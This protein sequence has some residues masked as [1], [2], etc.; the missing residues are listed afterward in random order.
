MNIQWILRHVLLVPF[1]PCRSLLRKWPKS[2]LFADRKM[3]THSPLPPIAGCS[4][5]FSSPATWNYRC[6][7][8]S[9]QTTIPVPASPRT[10]TPA[11]EL[12]WP[13][14]WESC[15]GT[16]QDHGHLFWTQGFNMIHSFVRTAQSFY[17]FIPS[18]TFSVLNS[19]APPSLVV[20]D[21]L[22]LALLWNGFLIPQ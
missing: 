21:C 4:M 11:Q 22:P 12:N 5:A 6:P 19:K 15:P 17:L 10:Q 13:L 8:W 1:W 7:T 16:L 18:Q 3:G 20:E 2:W 14:G 9:R